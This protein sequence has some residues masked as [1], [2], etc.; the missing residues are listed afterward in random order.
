MFRIA[1]DWKATALE[2]DERVKTVTEGGGRIMAAW[3]KEVVDAARHA[4]RRER[5]RDRE[6]CHR[7]RKRRIC[8]ATPTGLVEESKEPCTGGRRI[9]A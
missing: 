8:E 9:K 2:A 5:Q 1:R 6:S 7:T 3:G 4:R